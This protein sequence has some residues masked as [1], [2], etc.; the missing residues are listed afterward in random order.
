MKPNPTRPRRPWFDL[1]ALAHPAWWAA[2]AVLLVNDELLKGHGLV[3]GWLTGK[4]SDFAFLVVAPPLLAALLPRALPGRRAFAFASLVALYVA[5]DL[6]RAVSDGFV[7]LAARL[8]LTTKLWPDPTDLVAL[9]VLPLTIHLLRLRPAPSPD[10]GRDV[11]GR[12]GVILGAA[13]CIA[14]SAPRG[15]PHSPF[16]LNAGAGAAGLRVTW[17]LRKV[18]CDPPET[19]AATL[20]PND[21][22]DPRT[23]TIERGQVA[24]LDGVPRAGVSP[25]GSCGLRGYI[26]GAD[27]CVGAILESAG[28]APVLM[29]A[30]PEW[31][32][33]D[34]GGFFSCQ[35]PPSPVSRC[36]PRLDPAADPGPDAVVLGAT[37]GRLAFV[38]GAKAPVA[39]IDL[40]ALAARAPV[41]GGCRDLPADY[42]ALVTS[43]T[44]ASSLDCVGR[45]G[46]PVT[47]DAT[48]CEIDVNVGSLAAIDELG[49]RVADC[50]VDRA[51]KTCSGMLPQPAVCRGGFC[52]P[53]CPNVVVPPCP[54]RCRNITD[55]VTGDT[56]ENVPWPCVTFDGLTCACDD[57]HGRVV[58]GKAP[59]AAPGCPLSCIEGTGGGTFGD[60]LTDAGAGARSDA[61][62]ANDGA[63]PS[64]PDAG[65]L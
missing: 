32:E 28:A 43:P 8:G 16:L 38:G 39:P 35:N 48:A 58:C 52:A 62:P 26:D 19:V 14:T 30:R 3:P 49:R 5:A 59:P 61:A 20:A 46:L 13:A 7:A 45:A 51:V 40:A 50:Q 18:P 54:P 11:R 65:R 33:Y 36:G 6:S 56:C 42:Q 29:V 22:A 23:Y 2:L 53:V 17:V 55:P 21:L 34:G 64:A 9:A 12:A 4:L 60:G 1:T 63:P 37:G 57:R 25:V 41:V 24:V 10:R 47:D 44:C 15:Y 31:T 27:Q